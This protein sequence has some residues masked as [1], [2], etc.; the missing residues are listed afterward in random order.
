MFGLRQTDRRAAG[1]PFAAL[2]EELHALEALENGTLAT[3]GAAGL[4]AVMLG[5]DGKMVRVG[6][7]GAET[8]SDPDAWQPENPSYRAGRRGK[9]QMNADKR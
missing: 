3:N 8:R 7:R 4:E 6:T 9:P 5:H 2:L 1:L